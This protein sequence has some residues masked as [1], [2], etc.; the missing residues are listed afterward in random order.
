MVKTAIPPGS[1]EAKEFCA[2]WTINSHIVRL[3]QKSRV[4]DEK[5]CTFFMR[6]P[7]RNKIA[8]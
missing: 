3:L 1:N 4:L 2:N 6:P 5:K 7:L 8:L